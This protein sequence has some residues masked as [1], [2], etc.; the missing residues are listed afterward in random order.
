MHR[1]KGQSCRALLSLSGIYIYSEGG[2]DVGGG[3]QSVRIV[4]Q[5]KQAVSIPWDCRKEATTTGQE[6]VR[7]SKPEE[8]VVN[9][10]FN[11]YV[12]YVWWGDSRTRGLF[13]CFFM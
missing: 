12:M 4:A 5:S 9:H 6:R 1:P 13:A 2:L 8:V 7:I 11:G 10:M 3:G